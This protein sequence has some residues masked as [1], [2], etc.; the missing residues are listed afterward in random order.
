MKKWPKCLE[1]PLLPHGL[2]FPS[3][4]LRSDGEVLMISGREDLEDLGL[5]YRWFCM[6]CRNPLKVNSYHYTALSWDIPKEQW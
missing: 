2:L 3:L 1:C 5:V 4:H 6:V